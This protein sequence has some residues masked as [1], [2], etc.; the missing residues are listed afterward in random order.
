MMTLFKTFKNGKKILPR[1]P[2]NSHQDLSTIFTVFA[3]WHFI[4]LM[5]FKINCRH[6]DRILNEKKI[7]NLFEQRNSHVLFVD[8]SAGH[9][10]EETACQLGQFENCSQGWEWGSA[11]GQWG[12]SATWGLEEQEKRVLTGTRDRAVWRGLP[13]RRNQC[14][15]HPPVS[16]WCSLLDKCCQTPEGQVSLWSREQDGE[17]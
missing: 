14:Q 8:E 13:A 17:G 10:R 15:P 1:N 11:Q 2:Y 12:T 16:R 6:S 7:F 5:N 4:F 9:G 3:L